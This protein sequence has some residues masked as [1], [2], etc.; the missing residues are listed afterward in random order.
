M[1]EI[2]KKII[3]WIMGKEEKPQ[4]QPEGGKGSFETEKEAKKDQK[5]LKKEAPK[6][7]IAQPLV[8]NASERLKNELSELPD[9]NPE[10]YGLLM[11]LCAF[12]EANYKK[13]VVITMI[14][15]TQEEQDWL[16]RDS[17]KYKKR[18]FKSP[19][20]FWHAID[21]RSWIYTEKERKEMVK[22]LNERGSAQNNYYNWTAKVHEVG[23]NGL[24]FHVQFLKN[25]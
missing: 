22:F 16:Y 23:N 15:R 5:G 25:A 2:V 7:E 6:K 3:K 21:L 9:K 14:Y 18:K 8:K 12:V 1:V 10:L 13:D 4:K 11:D 20:Q 19:H 24:H 17:A